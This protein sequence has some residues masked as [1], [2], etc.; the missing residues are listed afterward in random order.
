MYCIITLCITTD[1][2]DSKVC[3]VSAYFWYQQSGFGAS[4][5]GCWLSRRRLTPFRL[6]V[7]EGLFLI[8]KI[9]T[10]ASF[11]GG[12]GG[13]DIGFQQTKRYKTE[14]IN[15][16]DKNAL[17]T[18]SANFHNVNIDGRDVHVVHDSDVPIVDV[19][20][21][22]FPC[23]AFSI[24]GY[25]KGFDDS[26]GELF[27]EMLRLIKAHKPRAILLENVKNLVSHN[28]GNTFLVIRNAL[29]LNGYYIKWK[30]MNAKDYGNLPQNRERI[31]I[32]GFR[33]RTA[34]DNFSFPK[35]IPLTTKCSD[36]ID[37]N[38]AQPD[39]YY[40]KS[41]RQP[42]YD[43]L[44]K[45]VASKNSIYQWRRQYVRENK[46]GVVPTLTANMGTGGH[47]VPIIYSD[48]G[49][50]KL[51][52]REAFNIMGFPNDYKLPDIADGQ[53]YKQ[54]GNS[55]VIPV[56]RRIADNI[57]HALDTDKPSTNE[58]SKGNSVI[59]NSV[60]G[61]FEGCSYSVTNLAS[62]DNGKVIDS[63]TALK[64]MKRGDAIDFY[65][66][67]E[68]QMSV[69]TNYPLEE[70]QLY[71]KYLQAYGALT[72][73]F[74]QKNNHDVP[75]LDS[76]FQE[77][78]YGKVFHSKN[79][80][81]GNTPHDIVSV[82][83][84]HHIG[85]GLKTWMNS[86]PSYQKVMQL[87]AYK[88]DI[89]SLGTDPYDCIYQI[90]A[91]KNSRLERDYIRLG[92]NP[93]DNIYHYITR[94]ADSF[95]IAETTYPEVR[96]NNLQ[97]EKSTPTSINWNDGV[98]EYKYTYGDTQVWM[99]FDPH[100]ASD[101]QILERFPVTTLD[102]PFT[103][104]LDMFSRFNLNKEYTSDAH[105]TDEV[106][107]PLYSC[108]TG[109]V[110]PKSGLNAWNAAP[111]AKGSQR[112]RPLSEIYIPV[113]MEF[114]RKNPTFFTDNIFYNIQHGVSVEFT[115]ILPNGQEMPGRLTGSNLKNFQSGSTTIRKPDG[116]RWGQ[117][118]LGKWLLIDVLGLH[119]RE[120]VTRHWLNQR[121]IDSIRLWHEHGDKSRIY[122][123]V[124]KVGSFERYMGKQSINC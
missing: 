21:G 32:V 93:D 5:F 90:S 112:L 110:E 89:I 41:G 8:S 47:N 67:A 101:T 96:L 109:E 45:S 15:E 49:I 121:G 54:A 78:I 71:I 76:K 83:N 68:W 88:D 61:L 44:A 40:Y 57:A 33:N 51:T 20:V 113:P 17:K 79:T 22:G 81:I 120:L 72:K 84:G 37:Y 59:F 28:N 35:P 36:L 105:L 52:P 43:Q 53:L 123:D 99:K 27:F 19:M 4:V 80:D 73:L 38:H 16:F 102:D 10:V 69:W 42:F 50:R 12:V 122:L 14:Y 31:Y 75:Y 46:S 34:F 30:V 77:T 48:S 29:V 116:K 114:H 95:T 13:I 115:I 98:K 107:L 92:L 111:K 24:A 118:D 3:N 62:V 55:V 7:S 6:L 74:T 18:L 63:N 60:H 70:R 1:V 58:D 91:I 117:S 94:D 124:A 11:F 85:I 9:Y 97:I 26:R 104:L 64:L 87:K 56:I 23:Q 2:I 86:K 106:Y 25:Q 82:I 65:L 66:R 108:S 100:N 39:K 119:N 103:F